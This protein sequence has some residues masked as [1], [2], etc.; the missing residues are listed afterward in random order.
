M[1]WDL[2]CHVVRYRGGYA[3]NIWERFIRV[4]GGEDLPSVTLEDDLFNITL[5]DEE[6]KLSKVD[7]LDDTLLSLLAKSEIPHSNSL[8]IAL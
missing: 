5:E 6:T 3:L 7:S 2:S 8:T 1:I 4:C